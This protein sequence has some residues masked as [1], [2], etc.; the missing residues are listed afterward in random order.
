MYLTSNISQFWGT[1]REIHT[2]MMQVASLCNL[3]NICWEHKSYAA[4]FASQ[5]F[6][7]KH[8]LLVV[9][10]PQSS[11]A[12]MAWLGAVPGF[13]HSSICQWTAPLFWY[14]F[15]HSLPQCPKGHFLISKY[16]LPIENT[17]QQQS[18]YSVCEPTG[19]RSSI[20]LA[21]S[22]MSRSLGIVPVKAVCT[23][24]YP[25]KVVRVTKKSGRP[26]CCMK[27]TSQRFSHTAW[28]QELHEAL[29]YRI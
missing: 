1:Q 25:S 10:E 2:F 5:A 11:S 8:V 13:T 29:D 15:L 21:I 27:A 23:C 4:S 17:F 6:L 9:S 7:D 19:W 12:I 18:E 28:S 16:P 20:F 3:S 24:G 14:S 22:S 26:R